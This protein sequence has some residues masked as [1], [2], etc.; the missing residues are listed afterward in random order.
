[1]LQWPNPDDHVS[2]REPRLLTPTKERSQEPTSSLKRIRDAP[3]NIA[4]QEP[5][6]KRRS[7]ADGL[8]LLH[9]GLEALRRAAS[10]MPGGEAALAAQL[11]PQLMQHM[12]R[13]LQLAG[14]M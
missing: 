4:I 10:L 2:T 11:R 13:V 6:A 1:M 7:T 3:K 12:Q 9:E 8:R 5:D 14:S